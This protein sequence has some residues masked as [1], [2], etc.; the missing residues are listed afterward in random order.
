VTAREGPDIVG[1]MV[2]GQYF[3][4]GL[5]GEGLAFEGS[6]HKWWQ[7]ASFGDG[8]GVETSGKVVGNF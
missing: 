4:F 3:E 7:V 2:Y 5:V 6:D 8:R 1:L